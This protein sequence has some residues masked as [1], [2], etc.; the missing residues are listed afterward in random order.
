MPAPFLA[1]HLPYLA[2]GYIDHAFGLG[3]RDLLGA[4][5]GRAAYV[6][7]IIVTSTCAADHLLKLVQVVNLQQNLL[8]ATINIPAGA[9][10]G[11]V[12]AVDLIAA[13][14]AVLQGGLLIGA[15]DFMRYTAVVAVDVGENLNITQYSVEL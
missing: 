1:G 9:G 12:P 8:I 6:W 2:S 14:P 11:T 15:G 7:G 4:P 3:S 10:N 5:T 13:L